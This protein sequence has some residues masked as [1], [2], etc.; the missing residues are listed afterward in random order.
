M[1]NRAGCGAEKKVACRKRHRA[2]RGRPVN[3]QPYVHRPIFPTLRIF[4][5]PTK[6]IHNPNPLFRTAL[7][8]FQAFFGYKAVCRPVRCQTRCYELVCTLISEVTERVSRE[9]CIAEL[10]QDSACSVS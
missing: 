10:K 9:P 5:I 4:P 8:P 3:R 7:G 6:R 2:N 1:L